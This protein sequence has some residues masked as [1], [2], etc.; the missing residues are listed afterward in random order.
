VLYLRFPAAKISVYLTARFFCPDYVT[1]NG[2]LSM[3]EIGVDAEEICSTMAEELRKPKKISGRYL[4]VE[5]PS[6]KLEW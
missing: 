5:L 6:T 1:P 2:G 4:N 3:K